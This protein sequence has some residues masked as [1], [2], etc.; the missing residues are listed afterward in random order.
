MSVCDKR[1]I[2]GTTSLLSWGCAHGSLG[3]IK[4]QLEI[5]SCK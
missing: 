2:V 3:E 4:A 1:E 5:Y